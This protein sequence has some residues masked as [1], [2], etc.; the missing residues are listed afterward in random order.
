MISFLFSG[1][2]WIF[3]FS[4]KPDKFL[5]KEV[6]VVFKIISIP[7][8]YNVKNISLANLNSID[9]LPVFLKAKVVD[10][11]KRINFLDSYSAVVK[12]KKIKN[13]YFVFIKKNTY[14]V[15]L[16]IS[17]FDRFR[18][19]AINFMLSNFKKN[20]TEEAYRFLSSVFLGR[21]E[22]L[23]K[24]E[25]FIFI[26]TGTIHL[27]AISGL[28]IGIWSL[29]LL[30]FLKIFNIKFKIRIIISLASLFVYTF[31][32]GAPPSAIRAFV[33]YAV[34]CFS[35]LLK[36]KVVSLNSLGLSGLVILFIWPFSVFDI[37][38]WLS[39][40][41]VFSLIIYS[42]FLNFNFSNF[43]INIF[44]SS[45][46]INLFINPI[47]SLYFKRLYILNIFY[48]I[49]LIPLFSLILFVNFLLIIFPINIF[50]IPTGKVLS[51]LIYIFNR[52]SLFFSNFKFNFINYKMPLPLFFIY[53]II[54]GFILFFIYFKKIDKRL[55]F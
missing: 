50:S 33:I 36:R 21:R 53:Y 35:F 10:Y 13:G 15:K 51:F 47:L 18:R 44:F 1:A 25:K 52:I 20:L 49:I 3:P 32:I 26:N 14:L 46:F 41:C 30:Y 11:S 6:Y 38:F 16:P 31:I 42:H 2:L 9:N 7:N 48:N 43:F 55:K 34:F 4:N 17:L 19:K 24:E 22:L 12:L 45:I 5:N 27:L 37:G 29:I 28:H 54:L 23:T 8:D 40:I 39:F